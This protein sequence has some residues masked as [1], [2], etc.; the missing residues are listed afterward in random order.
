MRCRSFRA[1][2][3][4]CELVGVVWA[5][6]GGLLANIGIDHTKSVFRAELWHAM[7]PV[8]TE[9][10]SNV[11]SVVL[12]KAEGARMPAIVPGNVFFGE[13]SQP[14]DTPHDG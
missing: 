9:F 13:P 5:A 10:C 12:A 6:L 4:N 8:K 7:Q 2:A 14:G 1:L 3:R 11:S